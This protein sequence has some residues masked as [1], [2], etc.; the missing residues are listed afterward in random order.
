MAHANG[1]ASTVMSEHQKH[2]EF[3]RQCIRYDDSARRHELVDEIARIQ[4]DARCVW[5]AVW[6]VAMLTAL[7]VAALGY[8]TLLVDHF[9]YN[10]P[11]FIVNSICALGLGSLI[12]LVA[13]VGLGMVYRRRL[14]RHREECR[15]RVAKL[16]ESRLGIP[17]T[18]SLRNNRAGEGDGRTVLVAGTVNGSLAKIEP[19]ARG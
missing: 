3:L 11:Q 19:V 10:T 13:F 1:V 2:T 18:A 14:D 5:R 12:S 9:P 7:A 4:R 15:E 17:V 16:L 6:F 8:G